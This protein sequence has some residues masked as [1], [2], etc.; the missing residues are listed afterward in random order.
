VTTRSGRNR[1]QPVRPGRSRRGG[2]GDDEGMV[3]AELAVGLP[4][5]VVVT[6]VA[7][8]IVVGVLDAMRCCDA[9]AVA[10]RMAARGDTGAAV[11]AAAD[12]AGPPG[13][14]LTV[15]TTATQVTATVRAAVR[16]PGIGRL[17]PAVQLVEH[18]TEAR[19]AAP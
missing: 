16:A 8:L 1:P 7:A 18:V 10:A 6:L 12:G 9:A 2:L 4:S 17:L 13:S 5:L 15:T 19:E 11:T 3:T 14:R